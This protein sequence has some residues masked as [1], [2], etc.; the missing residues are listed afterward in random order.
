MV[1]MGATASPG[2][3]PL[4]LMAN[5][6][7]EYLAIHPF[8][9]GNGRTSRLLTN[10]LLLQHGYLFATLASHERII[11]QQKVDYY[12]ALNKTQ[13]TWKGDQEDISPWLFFFLE[14][15]KRQ[16]EQALAL[17]AADDVTSLLSAKQLELWLWAREQVEF[18]RK[19]AIAALG[20]PPR[21]V[22]AIIKK[23]ME[24]RCLTRLGQGK[25]TRYRPVHST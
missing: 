14:V 24:L 23:L 10:L 6:I 5:F 3:H 11:E 20:F 21:T 12:L 2:K 13:S 19:D 15:V 1:S 4:I 16:S 22:E 17:L 8:Q 25:A 9:D 18:S 7:F